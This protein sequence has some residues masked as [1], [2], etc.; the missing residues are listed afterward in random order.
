MA[1]LAEFPLAS[2]AR[3]SS[4]SQ[5]TPATRSLKGG[6][7]AERARQTFEEAVGRTVRRPRLR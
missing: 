2:A 5:N 3:C 6:E 1:Q 7:V 4:R